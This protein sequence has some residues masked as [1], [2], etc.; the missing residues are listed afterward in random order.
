MYFIA[1]S[2]LE[3]LVRMIVYETNGSRRDRQ[4]R[5]SVSW[6][7]VQTL[8]S[9]GWSVRRRAPRLALAPGREEA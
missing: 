8:E 6:A 2:L 5:V 4:R 1:S 9:E 7:T 3:G